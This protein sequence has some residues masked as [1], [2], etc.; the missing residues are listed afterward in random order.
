LGLL[1][2]VTLFVSALLLFLVQPMTG[3]MLLPKLGGTP[4]VWNCCMLFFQG[5]LLA[6]YFYA[7]VLATR[8][9]VRRQ[10]AVH[11]SVLILPLLVLPIRLADNLAPPADS[12]PIPWLLG[13]LLVNVGLPFFVLSTSAP[14]LQK[15]FSATGSASGRDPYYLYAA[16]NLGSMLALIGYPTLVEPYLPLK[17]AQLWSQSW[18]WAFGYG[19][20]VVLT[21]LC[22]RKVWQASADSET[23]ATHLDADSAS[24]SAPSLGT[25]A[26]WIALAFVPS[27][28]MLSVTTYATLDI[29]ALP[30]LWI[31][32]LVLY[33]LSFILVFARWPAFMHTTM[34]L[35]MPMLLLMLV[36]M[37]IGGAKPPITWILAIHFLAF[38]VV[39]MVCHGELARTR[40]SVSYLT[41]FYLLISVGGVLG[42]IFNALVA[43]Y[44]FNGLA[45]YAI[46]IVLACLLM[47]ALRET[48]GWIARRFAPPWSSR[49]DILIDVALGCLLGLFA[50]ALG[51]FWFSRD[52][53]AWYAGLHATTDKYLIQFCV[54]RDWPDSSIEHIRMLIAYGTP[55]VLC[56]LFASRPLRLGLGVAGILLASFIWDMR[57]SDR[58]LHQER[59]FFGVIKV[60]AADDITNRLMHGTTLHG[61][62]IRDE[63]HRREPQTYYHRTGPIGQLFEVLN[64]PLRKN[65]IALIGLGSGTLTCYGQP[66]QRL[67]I[68]DINPAIVRVAKNSDYF[69]YLQDCEA[70]TQIVMGD[71]RLRLAEA[72]DGSYGLIVVDA[73]SSDAI[74]I[75][76]ITR[77][78]LQLY[79]QKLDEHGVLAIHISN[80]YLDLQPVLAN[81]AQDQGW[82]AFDESD[83]IEDN[84]TMPG[85]ER[86]EWV[87]LARRAEDLGELQA[88][89]PK[90]APWL[91]AQENPKV[92]IWSDDYSNLLGVFR[93]N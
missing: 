41:K 73:F 47:P 66:G 44:L 62:Q 88:R 70:E 87:V 89:A 57:T 90:K 51:A 55:A 16:S 42:G 28:L 77:E 60:E 78:A 79:F 68:Y 23:A 52:R 18:I 82:V 22:A 50:Y 17:A 15:W 67:T 75:H 29:A 46:G 12:T 30:L 33:L 32:P 71:A 76:L 39:A 92:G 5:M 10:I 81:I 34:I 59:N 48:R 9:T 72:K 69:S 53:D 7:H 25:Q 74:P 83:N 84:Q 2:A 58:V 21:C 20:L 54:S 64:G 4:A 56:Y 19:V 36:Y 1:Y 31:I 37:M 40:P 49:V 27:S 24:E 26:R 14:L 38:F 63:A 86:S 43:P 6:G 85:K 93:W 8:L 80:R 35:I 61:K 65:E 91:P 11:L 13:T 45:E 3:K